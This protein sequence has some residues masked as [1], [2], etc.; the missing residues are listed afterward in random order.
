MLV[1]SFTTLVLKYDRLHFYIQIHIYESYSK[2]ILI[3]LIKW[4]VT[5]QPGGPFSSCNLV[6]YVETSLK[7][8]HIVFI[9]SRVM[10]SDVSDCLYSILIG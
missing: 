2:N 9:V 3:I 4:S 5:V 10:K 1:L 8:I 6:D 7:P